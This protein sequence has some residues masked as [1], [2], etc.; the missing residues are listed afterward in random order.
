MRTS[1]LPGL[2]SIV[3]ENISHGEQNLKLYEWGEVFFRDDS[4][5]L[6]DERVMLAA[7]ITDSVRLKK[8]V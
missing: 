4:K 7:V 3:K 8:M 5:E 2:L 6:P 1:L